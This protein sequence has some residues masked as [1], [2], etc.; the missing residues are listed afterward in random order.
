MNQY[1]DGN[2]HIT[3]RLRRLAAFYFRMGVF[4]CKRRK[5]KICNEMIGIEALKIYN[6]YGNSLKSFYIIWLK[7]YYN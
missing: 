3:M 4:Y 6:I 5:S 7:T 2:A 1:L